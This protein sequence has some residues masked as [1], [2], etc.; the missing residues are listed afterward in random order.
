MENKLL[1]YLESF[2][3]DRRV[4]LFKEVASRRTH[5]FTIVNEDVRHLHNT[6]AVIRSC[7][8][9]GI[10]DVHVIEEKIGRRIDKEIAMGAQKWT[11]VHRYNNVH[12]TISEL[13]TKGYR[14][15]ATTPHHEAHTLKDFDISKPAA[16]FFGREAEGLS[17]T[18]I[19][20]ADDYIYIPTSGFTHSLNI[21]VSAAIIIQN[22]MQRLED[23]DLDWRLSDN[24]QQE[25]RLQWAQRHIKNLDAILEGF[26][27]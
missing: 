6:S 20:A 13:R 27:N 3:T 7:D 17:D 26:K 10:Q 19:D 21:S 15:V 5:H 4:S 16:L 1:T 8:A 2:L 14:I 9:F 24:D 25:L 18:V 22:L 23:S 11:T 12:D